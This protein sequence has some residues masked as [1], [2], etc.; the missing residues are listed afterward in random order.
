MMTTKEFLK[1]IQHA[2]EL[3]KEVALTDSVDSLKEWDSVGHLGILVAIDKKLGGK[4]GKIKKLV[5]CQS[6]KALAETLKKNKFLKD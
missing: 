2:L 4:A 6:V 3:K 1:T 5:N